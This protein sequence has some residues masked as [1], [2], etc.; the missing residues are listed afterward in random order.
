MRLWIVLIVLCAGCQ[1]TDRPAVNLPP[2]TVSPPPELIYGGTC[3][4]ADT[5]ETWLQTTGFQQRDFVDLMRGGV[6]KTPDDLYFDVEQM[7]RLRDRIAALTAPDCAEELHATVIET[8]NA[9]I[10]DYQA[11]VNEVEGINLATVISRFEPQ[12]IV[13]AEQQNELIQRLP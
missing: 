2:L 9:V 10:V 12:F 6:D 3:D 5:L 7:A 8:M 11:Y 4:D 13:L 1:V